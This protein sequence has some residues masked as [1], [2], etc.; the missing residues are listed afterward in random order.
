MTKPLSK[1]FAIVSCLV[2]AL[3]TSSVTAPKR[4]PNDLNAPSRTI[5]GITLGQSNLAMVRAKLGAANLGGD[6]DGG[7]AESKVCYL[8]REP[9][10]LVIIYAANSEM[11]PDQIV[12]NI[13][14]LKQDAYKDRSNCLPLTID[15]NGVSTPSHL[16]IGSTREKVRAI[17]G[18]PT[19]TV[20]SEWS[21]EWSVDRAIPRSDKYYQRWIDKRQEC[22]EGRAPYYTTFSDITVQFKDDLAVALFFSRTDSVC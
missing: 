6:G 10:S 14:I 1:K 2:L 20:R 9:N 4:P 11:S 21:Y 22:F 17:L 12:T 13:R 8:T 15:G 3:A 19:R 16:K 7:N 18:A 5:L